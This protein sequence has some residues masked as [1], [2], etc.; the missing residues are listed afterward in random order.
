VGNAARK[1][2]KSDNNFFI[3][4]I[5]GLKKKKV[6]V[7]VE[8]LS[9]LTRG[10]GKRNAFPPSTKKGENLVQED[11]RSMCGRIGSALKKEPNPEKLK[12][13]QGAIL[14]FLEKNRG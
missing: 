3:L 1:K 11:A 13:R 9:P 2:G 8:R 6:F 14:F 4:E 10:S 5:K 7:L 12:H